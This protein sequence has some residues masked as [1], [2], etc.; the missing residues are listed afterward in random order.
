MLATC[1][2]LLSQSCPIKQCF[3]VKTKHALL[4]HQPIIERFFSDSHVFPNGRGSPLL[5]WGL[6]SFAANIVVLIRVYCI[7]NSFKG[8]F[9]YLLTEYWIVRPSKVILWRRSLSD[10]FCG[11]WGKCNLKVEEN[12]DKDPN[13]DLSPLHSQVRGWFRIWVKQMRPHSNAQQLICCFCWCNCCHFSFNTFFV[14]AVVLLLFLLLLLL[15]N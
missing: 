12:V 1:I 7:S 5:H 8:Q 3:N 6:V 2:I 10:F 11:Q 13:I 9:Q 4:H 15:Q 14:V